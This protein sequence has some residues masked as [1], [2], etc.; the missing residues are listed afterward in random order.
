MFGHLRGPSFFL[1]HIKPTCNDDA[2]ARRTAKSS[3]RRSQRVVRRWP[4]GVIAGVGGADKT[5]MTFHPQPK[6]TGSSSQWFQ[7]DEWL[8]LNMLQTGHCRD[9]EVWETVSNDY[10]K[11]PAKPVVNGENSYE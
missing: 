2:I 9:T 7:R 1:S 8:D 4:N 3:C 6:G 10:H 11:T 5:L